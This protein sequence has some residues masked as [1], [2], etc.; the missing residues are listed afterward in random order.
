MRAILTKDGK[1]IARLEPIGKKRDL[2]GAMRG[3]VYYEGD[4]ISPIDVEWNVL[5]DD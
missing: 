5:K 3:S 1:P 4:I 2:F